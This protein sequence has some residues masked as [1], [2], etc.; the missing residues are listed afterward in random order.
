MARTVN[1]F[2]WAK[3]LL[4]GAMAFQLTATQAMAA[5]ACFTRDDNKSISYDVFQVAVPPPYY[6]AGKDYV[7]SNAFY[8]ATDFV[9]TT[10]QRLSTLSP[11]SAS[12]YKFRKYVMLWVNRCIQLPG[13]TP[14]GNAGCRNLNP[15]GNGYY[16]MMTDSAGAPGS[17]CRRPPCHRW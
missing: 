10:S 5:D 4:A 1:R 15:K 3:G 9:S 14:G 13:L 8:P 6:V 2:T 17:W 11:A 7:V 16:L 12:G